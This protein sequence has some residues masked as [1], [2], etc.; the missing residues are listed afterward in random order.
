MPA[1][2]AYGGM[3]AAILISASVGACVCVCVC[4]CGGGGQIIALALTYFCVSKPIPG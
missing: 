4:V 2:F 1:G 3:C